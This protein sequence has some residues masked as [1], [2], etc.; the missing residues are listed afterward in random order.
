ML[1]DDR[2]IIAVVALTI[3]GVLVGCLWLKNYECSCK[4]EKQG[5]EHSWGPIQGCMVREQ[6]GNW[7]DYDRLRVMDK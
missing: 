2:F 7:I 1:N 3:I 4:A 6:G 5:M